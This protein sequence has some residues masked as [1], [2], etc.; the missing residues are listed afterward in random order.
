MGL[1]ES[2]DMGENKV[3]DVP[4]SDTGSLKF[5]WSLDR[6]TQQI[7]LLAIR[8]GCSSAT[9]TNAPPSAKTPPLQMLVHS[10]AMSR[11]CRQM[12]R[13]PSRMRLLRAEQ[14]STHEKATGL[15][16]NTQ[17]PWAAKRLVRRYRAMWWNAKPGKRHVGRGRVEEG[18]SICKNTQMPAGKSPVEI[19]TCSRGSGDREVKQGRGGPREAWRGEVEQSGMCLARTQLIN[20]CK[21][22]QTLWLVLCL[23]I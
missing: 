9:T 14:N 23:H 8:W 15:C 21:R 22:S 2:Y 18:G 6:P 19:S 13:H 17:T 11:K 1:A 3:A 16:T 12:P 7:I 4:R 10:T 20:M 5:A